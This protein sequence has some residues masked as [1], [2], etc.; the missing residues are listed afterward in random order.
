M[1]D[2][3]KKRNISPLG[4]FTAILSYF[5]YSTSDIFVKIFS[6]WYSSVEIAFLLR[7]GVSGVVVLWQALFIPF[8]KNRACRSAGCTSY[9]KE[10]THLFWR[11]RLLYKSTEGFIEVAFRYL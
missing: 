3:I 11:F 10:T 4:V 5:F 7:I 1:Q 6:Q 9:M 2:N 8:G